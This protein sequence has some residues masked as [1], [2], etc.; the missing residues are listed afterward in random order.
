MNLPFTV[1]PGTT[2]E[3]SLSRQTDRGV[4]G[5]NLKLARAWDALNPLT[6]SA[7]IKIVNVRPCRDVA[8][9]LLCDAM[10]RAMTANGCVTEYDLARTGLPAGQITELAPAAALELAG[11]MTEFVHIATAALCLDD[12]PVAT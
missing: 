9:T 10:Y 4:S 5:R 7:R 12:H 3:D 6:R 2:A 1:Y 11:A 8:L